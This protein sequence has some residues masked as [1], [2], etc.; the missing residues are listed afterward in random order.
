VELPTWNGGDV[1]PS[2]LMGLLDEA[3]RVLRQQM[4]GSSMRR[5]DA[6]DL[7]HAIEAASLLKLVVDAGQ[8]HL[9]PLAAAKGA[10]WADLGAAVGAPGPATRSRFA[11]REQE[12]APWEDVE[13]PRVDAPGG[14]TPSD[15]DVVRADEP[16]WRWD[17][18]LELGIRFVRSDPGFFVVLVDDG[19]RDVGRE[20]ADALSGQAREDFWRFAVGAY[21][22]D[23]R[24]DPV[25]ARPGESLAAFRAR[26]GS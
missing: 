16:A 13:R 21:L 1:E 22:G 17:G 26:Q 23:R 2:E 24:A 15:D 11:G 25:D 5:S 9:V 3:L 8:E 14:F 12:R 6:A 18:D 10:S 19:G 7:L 20:G 4:R